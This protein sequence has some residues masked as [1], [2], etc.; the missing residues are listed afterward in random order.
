MYV[1]F[2]LV[3]NKCGNI[4]WCLI[5]RRHT[6]GLRWLATLPQYSPGLFA[7]VPERFCCFSD[8]A[9]VSAAA[10]S[11]LQPAMGKPKSNNY[12]LSHTFQLWR[13]WSIKIFLIW[14]FAALVS[15]Y[16]SVSS[17]QFWPSF[18]YARHA[19]GKRSLPSLALQKGSQNWIRASF[20]SKIILYSLEYIT[21]QNNTTKQVI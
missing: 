8:S 3:H 6:R 16:S 14:C 18:C 13:S 19:P 4:G 5:H 11:R 9:V 17:V 15:Y 1:G 7:P 21:T 2:L 20:N 10:A 12:W